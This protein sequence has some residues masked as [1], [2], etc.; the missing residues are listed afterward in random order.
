M[1]IVLNKTMIKRIFFIITLVL[2]AFV[3]FL[4]PNFKTI[5]AGVSIFL[6]GMV[7]LE[8]GFKI[9]SGGVL[10]KIL[11]KSTEN[12]FK[13]IGFGAL[14]TSIMQSSSL[15][16]VL[17][18]SFLGAGLI[19]LAQGIGIVFGANIGTTT[20][21]WLMAGFGLKVKISAYA[22]PMLVFGIIL[23]FQKAKSFKGIGYILAGLGFLFLGIH[24]MKGGFEAFKETI[25]LAKFSV[26]GYKG[27]FIFTGIGIF[28][29]VIMQSSHATLMLILTALA[30]GQISYENALALAI[31]AN[32]GTTITAII[33]SLSSN[34]NGKR[35][36]AAHLI[37]NLVTGIIAIVFIYQFM[38]VVDYLALKLGVA[39]NN[40]TIKLAIFH[41]VFNVVG[42]LVM[43][44][45]IGVLEK[46][47]LKF[48]KEKTHK[49][50]DEPKYLNKS[51]LEF[52]ETA[53]TALLNESKY[54]YKNAVFE[55]VSHALNI[56]REDIKSDEKIKNIIKKSTETI[57]IDVEEVYYKK[58]K[59][60]YGEIIKYATKAQSKLQLSE[61]QAKVISEIKLAN[62]KMVEI[63]RDVRELR[64]NVSIYLNSDNEYI[65]KEYNKFRKKVAKVLR[66]IYLFRKTDEKEKEKYYKKLM[67]LKKE[68]REAIHSDY[69]SI[70]KLIRNNLITSDMVSSLVNDNDNVNDLIKKLIAVA[71]LLYVGKDQLFDDDV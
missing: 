51:I 49:D 1:F 31:G 5:A 11:R 14:I 24:Y 50:I 38:H 40:H 37:F 20:G 62:R 35:L 57:D 23:I 13:S 64:K 15:V 52:P 26:G 67:I 22:M 28:A 42:V 30:T 21:A 3:L 63:I 27:I 12:T 9:F 8:D 39:N 44:P 33:G 71:E 2:L 55:I 29:T 36:A 32:V 53:I 70:D 58:V 65:K 43:V 68:A 6:F 66:V 69:K 56:H 34:I 60:I 46:F 16:S 48:L 47:L 61:N 41:T 45:F 7:F 17:T 59:T 10:E 18:I 54:L 25:D 4:N 19:E